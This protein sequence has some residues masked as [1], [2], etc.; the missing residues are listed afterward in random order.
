MARNLKYFT[1]Y[2][3]MAG[4]AITLIS[5]PL[6]SSSS[7]KA[8][9]SS[10]ASA[11][12]KAEIFTDWT[13]ACDNILNCTAQGLMKE[14]EFWDNWL[15]LDIERAAGPKGDATFNANFLYDWPKDA[16]PQAKV[17]FVTNEGMKIPLR[18]TQG[19]EGMQMW[20]MPLDAG[21]VDA[22]RN[23]ATVEMKGPDGKTLGIGSLAGL[24]A[25]LRYMDDK[26][27]RTDGVTALIAR[28]SKPANAVT[29]APIAPAVQPA[30]KTSLTAYQ[31]TAAEWAALKSRADC[32]ADLDAEYFETGVF[33]LD[34]ATT[35]VS[36]PCSHGAYNAITA[37]YIA[38]K[39]GTGKAA[40]MQFEAL[41][42]DHAVGD[43]AEAGNLTFLVNSG[44]DTDKHLLTHYVK[45]RGI[46]DCGEAAQWVW[47]GTRFRMT[48][49]AV[50]NEC[51]GSNNWL[52]VWTA[53]NGE[54]D[55]G[56]AQLTL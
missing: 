12:S 19:S 48:Y 36:V 4:C 54:Q 34:A 25:T 28:G 56:K 20:T 1:S 29:S 53:G 18:V 30:P 50:M 10:P 37:Y 31:P 47:D 16:P 52:R 24:S 39:E 3:L 2:G 43:P 38:R 14:E 13:V 22:L 32:D 35:L 23:A 51:R 9:P 21:A 7:A 55:P 11:P 8:A 5:L 41:P 26:Q 17:S 42:F 15:S 46:G 40:K 45:G 49:L 44:Y 6:G 27:G 33:R